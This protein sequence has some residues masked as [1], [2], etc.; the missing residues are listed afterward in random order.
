M[1]TRLRP[2]AREPVRFKASEYV[3][4]VPEDVPRYEGPYEV[5]PSGETQVL[6]TEGLL[7]EQG[8]TVNPI[9]SNY[10]LIT[11]NGA[12]LTVS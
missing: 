1:P 3:P 8:V 9:P 6:A 5:T 7:M 4:F 10:G 11:W 12:Y 2:I